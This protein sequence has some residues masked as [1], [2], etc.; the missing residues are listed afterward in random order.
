MA[1]LTGTVEAWVYPERN[2]VL[3]IGT[4]FRDMF[5]PDFTENRLCY[6]GNDLLYLMSD[7][8]TDHDEHVVLESWDGPPDPA[9]AE[10][11]DTTHIT[12]TQP[13]VYVS[14]MAETAA[15]AILHLPKSGVYL[16]EVTVTGRHARAGHPLV[17]QAAGQRPVEYLRV[18]FWPA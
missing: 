18:R 11:T 13:G 7:G 12:L 16:A 4:G 9:E 10:F 6:G 15:S 1:R 3:V 2:M 8:R 17:V 14:R 5:L